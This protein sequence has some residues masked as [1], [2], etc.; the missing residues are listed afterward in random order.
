[1]KNNKKSTLEDAVVW[2]REAGFDADLSL[3][4]AGI[5]D[6]G[7]GIDDVVTRI[8]PT[9]LEAR[10]NQSNEVLMVIEDL[11][12]QLEHISKHAEELRSFANKARKFFEV[13]E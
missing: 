9:L 8:L 2:F 6:I 4:V 10:T 1:M 3:F 11:H 5:L 13:T 7:D 12:R